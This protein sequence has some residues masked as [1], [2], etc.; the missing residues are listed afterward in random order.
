[1]KLWRLEAIRGL[2]ALYIVVSH[3]LGNEYFFL[4][5]GQEAV[6][7]FFMMSGFVIEYSFQNSRYQNFKSYFKKRFCASTRF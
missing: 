2:A 3:V 1:M 6:M 7:I 5:F 4:R